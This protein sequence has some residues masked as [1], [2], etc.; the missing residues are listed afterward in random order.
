MRKPVIIGNWKMNKDLDEAKKL[1][2][3]IISEKLDN[4]V[5]KVVCVPFV[6]VTEVRKLFFL[7]LKAHLQVK[8]LL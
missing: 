5:E 7:K 6:Y 8:F 1:V 3:E 4:N 2:K